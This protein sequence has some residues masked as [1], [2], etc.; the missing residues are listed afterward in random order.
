MSESLA[1]PEKQAFTAQAVDLAVKELQ[2]VSVDFYKIQLGHVR[3]LIYLAITVSTAIACAVVHFQPVELPALGSFFFAVLCLSFAGGV[4]AFLYGVR[5]LRGG[6]TPNVV[7][8]YYALADEVEQ[9]SPQ[10][11]AQQ[12]R[13]VLLSRLDD[14]IAL[15]GIKMKE[16]AERIRL[17]NKS[18]LAVSAVAAFATLALFLIV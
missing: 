18:I 15:N 4:C 14:A 8:S 9:V 10:Y 6:E 11:D 1:S 3:Q 12:A 17:L 2:R 16:K 7:P 13:L 5:S